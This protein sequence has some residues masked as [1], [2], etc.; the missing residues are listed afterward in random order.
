M[1]KVAKNGK[2]FFIFYPHLWGGKGLGFVSQVDVP[3]GRHLMGHPASAM[4]LQWH[5]S[6]GASLL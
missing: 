1:A 4:A 3:S 6:V 2:C 5:V